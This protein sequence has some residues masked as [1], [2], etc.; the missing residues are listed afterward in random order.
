ME[1]ARKLTTLEYAEGYSG[2]ILQ[3]DIA[4]LGDDIVK[5]GRYNTRRIMVLG[6]ARAW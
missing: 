1:L 5:Q 2:W 6:L 3:P 4:P